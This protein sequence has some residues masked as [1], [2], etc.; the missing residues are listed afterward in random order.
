M[1]KQINFQKS[2]FA[3]SPSVLPKGN[4]PPSS[5]E[6]FGECQLLSGTMYYKCCVK[7]PYEKQPKSTRFFHLPDF[8]VMEIDTVD[9]EIKIAQIRDKAKVHNIAVV[10][11]SGGE[12]EI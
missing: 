9:H 12:G 6:G 2:L 3:F 7:H 5:E 8:F 10:D 4:P 1:C 11:L